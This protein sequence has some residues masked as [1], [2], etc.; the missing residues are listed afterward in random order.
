MNDTLDWSAPTTV[1]CGEVPATDQLFDRLPMNGKDSLRSSRLRES[2]S[3]KLL[4]GFS[5]LRELLMR[6]E[7][8][9]LLVGFQACAI[10]PPRENCT[11]QLCQPNGS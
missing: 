1:G 5:R 9:L 6:S 10:H 2:Y 3:T 8:Y 4:Y 11:V 7:R